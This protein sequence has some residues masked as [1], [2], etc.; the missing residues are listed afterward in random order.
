MSGFFKGIFGGKEDEHELG[1]PQ[2]DRLE[3]NQNEE[4]ADFDA[5]VK[6]TLETELDPVMSVEAEEVEPVELTPIATPSNG[7]GPDRF[8]D[9][10]PEP[11]QNDEFSAERVWNN[12]GV[13]DLEQT[14][15]AKAQHLLNSLP[16]E[17]PAN[18][19][20]QIVEASLKAFEVSIDD[21]TEGAES[22]INALHDYIN[23]R[24]SDAEHF[25]AES[26]TRI[27]ELETE[28]KRIR[29]TMA[30]AEAERERL[31]GAANKVINDVKP[32]LEFFSPGSPTSTMSNKVASRPNSSPPSTSG[33]LGGLPKPGT[34]VVASVSSDDLD[35]F[36][37]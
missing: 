28:I 4:I 20:R 12:S 19:K 35:E 3:S 1:A 13:T 34:P 17:T 10:A 37:E 31:V 7:A 29:D 32:V 24:N 15:V 30:D 33:I 27:G 8:L 16:D 9:N 21:I 23:D 6:G 5:D 36:E 11:P 22:E 18:V 26:E 2:M 14:T 25:K